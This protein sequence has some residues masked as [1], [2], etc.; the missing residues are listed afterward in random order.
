VQFTVAVTTLAEVGDIARFD[1]PR[2]LTDY[3]G[4]CPSEH[5][6]GEKRRL[7][8]ISKTGNSH[9]R[10]VLIEGAWAY[11][12]PA[13]ISRQIQIRQEN[14]PQS[15]RDIAWK[16]QLRLCKRYRR[17]TARGKHPNVAVTAIARELASFM[18]AI[19]RE[20]APIT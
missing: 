5:S 7:G 13:R 17:L 14:L 20:I 15:I 6:T 8:G 3:L 4:L 9:A 10:R 19:A 16:A 11:R 12:Y 18:W 2:Q 1:N